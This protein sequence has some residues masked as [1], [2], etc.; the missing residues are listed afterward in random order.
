MLIAD[1]ILLATWCACGAA[2]LGI[3]AEWLHARR[4][5]RLGRLAFGPDSQPRLWTQIAPPLRVIALSGVVWSLIVLMAFEGS[6]RANER[7]SKATRHLMVMLDVSPS[8]QL[9]DA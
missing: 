8:M 3:F 4:S 9:Q 6:N 2:V 7:K 5:R 1:Y